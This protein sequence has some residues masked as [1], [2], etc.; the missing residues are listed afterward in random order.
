[1]ALRSTIYRAD[2]SVSDLDREVYGQHALTLARHPS[3]TE[4]RLMVRLFAFALYADA[5]LTF[6][7]GLSTEDEP[8]LCKRDPTGAIE[9]WIDVGLPSDKEVRKACGRARSVVVIA[10]GARRVEDWWEQN[11]VTLAR[12]A[13]LSVLALSAADTT[14]LQSLAARSM[15]LACTIQD[16]H[17]WLASDTTSIEITPAWK[18]TAVDA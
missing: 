1:M 6:G 7:R 17:V 12:S 2:L 4:E 5:A 15:Q 13:N 3:E 11:A 18:Q 9:W 14:A 10:Y 16:R 8:D